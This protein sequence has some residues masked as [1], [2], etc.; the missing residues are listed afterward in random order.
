MSV[1]D[2][3]YHEGAC[4]ACRAV[5]RRLPRPD[6][7]IGRREGRPRAC[8]GLRNVPAILVCG[9]CEVWPGMRRAGSPLPPVLSNVMLD[10]LDR[11]LWQRG[12]RFARYADLRV[13]V[14]SERAAQRVFKSGCGAIERRLRLKV[15]REKSSIRR[16]SSRSLPGP[17]GRTWAGWPSVCP[18]WVQGGCSSGFFSVSGCRRPSFRA[19]GVAARP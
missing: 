19:R 11:E 15:N 5:L 8:T 16:R 12:H 14:C 10:D 1:Q 6:G 13:F 7:T 3:R 18:G 2:R 4:D 9:P 17:G